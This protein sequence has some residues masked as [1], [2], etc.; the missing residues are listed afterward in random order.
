MSSGASGSRV[1]RQIDA[2]E[3]TG[4]IDHLESQKFVVFINEIS[5]I[6]GILDLGAHPLAIILLPALEFR[7]KPT[8]VQN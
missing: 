6:K 3:G 4:S 8:I 1:G 7:G 5:F 2:Q